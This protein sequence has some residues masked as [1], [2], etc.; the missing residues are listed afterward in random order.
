MGDTA[1][2][3]LQHRNAVLRDALQLILGWVN[4]EALPK[5]ERPAA[6]HAIRT[7]QQVLIED[8]DDAAS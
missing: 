6:E 8:D 4:V 3:V 1:I 2:R 7:A 5:H